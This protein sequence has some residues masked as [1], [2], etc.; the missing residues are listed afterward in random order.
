MAPGAVAQAAA[1]AP[2]QQAAPLALRRASLGQ[3]GGQ[4]TAVVEGLDLE[5]RPGQ[6][7]A[8]TGESGCG[9]TTLLRA[10]A[11]LDPLLDGV[12]TLGGKR[13]G[14]DVAPADWRCRVCYNAQALPAKPGFSD[15]PEKL[16]LHMEELAAMQRWKS[17]RARVSELARA[18][19]AE[20]GLGGTDPA[21]GAEPL[22]ARPWQQLS[23]GQRQRLMLAIALAREPDFLLLDEP[24]SALDAQN[25]ALV[26]ETLKEFV[27]Q[28]RGLVLVTHSQ[29]QAVRMRSSPDRH[30]H[31][32][33]PGAWQLGEQRA[34]AP[35]A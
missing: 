16:A 31:I 26:E 17:G 18:L 13:F 5:L 27:A 11:G 6:V 30:L 33:G 1:A 10:L 4:T 35:Q 9:K 32:S 12:L 28:G 19:I 2:R 3:A 25:T 14:A 22:F 15:S 24:T 7:L 21:E 8:V 23:G 20:W 29:E 34:A